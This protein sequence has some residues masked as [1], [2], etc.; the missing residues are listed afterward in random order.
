[1]DDAPPTTTLLDP[2][3]DDVREQ[4]A[5]AARGILDRPSGGPGAGSACCDPSADA[6]FGEIL[7]DAADRASL[8]DAAVLASLGC[9]NPTA[10]AEL[11]ARRDRPGPRVRR[12]DRRPA[13][14]ASVSGRPAARSAST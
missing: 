6:V 5:E 2:V 14:R 12:R 11:R 10:V 9:G 13:L 8:P 1:M 7:Y 3:T 4:Y